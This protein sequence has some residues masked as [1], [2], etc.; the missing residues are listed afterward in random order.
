MSRYLFSVIPRFVSGPEDLVVTEHKSASFTCQVYPPKSEVL[1]L[2]NGK[3]TGKN[4]RCRFTSK[5]GQ[6]EMLIKD[7]FEE[8]EGKVFVFVGEEQREA[9]LVVKGIHLIPRYR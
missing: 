4:K 1:W 8:D 6:H 5:D 9:N 2:I 3:E 7:A